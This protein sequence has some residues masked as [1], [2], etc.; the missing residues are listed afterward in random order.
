M[1]QLYLGP[2][3]VQI[4][5]P[6]SFF[7]IGSSQYQAMISNICTWSWWYFG[8][9]LLK[10]RQYIIQDGH[11]LNINKFLKNL[12]KTANRILANLV[13]MSDVQCSFKAVQMGDHRMKY[14]CGR[15]VKLWSY[16]TF[17]RITSCQLSMRWSLWCS[18]CW[19]RMIMSSKVAAET[20]K[21]SSF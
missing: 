4:W 20:S 17:H 7:R 15:G 21:R 19:S 5:P 9:G 12:A 10:W 18:F 3:V 8:G 6:V 2:T 11:R 13:K 16:F 14:T 1:Y